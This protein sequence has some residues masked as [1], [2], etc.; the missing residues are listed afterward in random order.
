[1]RPFL[2]ASW[3]YLAMLNYEV[4]PALLRP[5]VPLG[6]ELDTWDGATLASMVGFRFLDTRV[7]GIPIPGHRDFDEV[8]LRFYVRRRGED[9]QW[10]R[11]VVFVRELVPRRGIAFVARWF[12]NEPY[13][14]VPMRH[15]LQMANAADGQSGCAA[16]AW[17]LA[18]RWHRLEVRTRGR[19]ALPDPTSEA[20][21]TTEHYWGYTVQ[22]DG[23]SKEYRVEHPPWRVWEA[24]GTQFDC[25]V[26]AVYGPSFGECLGVQPRSAFLAEGSVVT[27]YRGRC[28]DLAA[29]ATLPEAAA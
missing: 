21:F 12:Y 23:G 16:Y 6:T 13:T 1:S 26:K 3:R 11:A 5:L 29:R 10:R 4:P 7:L 17:R 27:V 2:T 28:L 9:G 24:E 22:R 18:D 25:D 20:A 19:P 15:E 8:N 14:V